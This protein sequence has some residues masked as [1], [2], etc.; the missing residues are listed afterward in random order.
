MAPNGNILCLDKE[1]GEWTLDWEPPKANQ[2][3]LHNEM[4]VA[5]ETSRAKK[6]RLH[7]KVVSASETSQAQKP[8]P[9]DEMVAATEKPEASETS[10]ESED[11]E[12]SNACEE[13]A[14]KGRQTTR[15]LAVNTAVSYTHLT[16]PTNR[17]V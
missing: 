5:S 9:H 3:R 11:F 12:A 10:E 14:Q 2:Q 13:S 15:L 8:C 16:L 7:D 6:P 4:V 1:G 17:E